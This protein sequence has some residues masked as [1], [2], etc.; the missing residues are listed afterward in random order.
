MLEKLVLELLKK[1]KRLEKRGFLDYRE[2]KVENNVIPR[3]EGSSRVKIGNTEVIAGIK[4]ELSE[5][6]KDEKESGVLIVNAE[7]API[8]HATFE[9]GPP[10]EEAIELAR[11]VDRLIRSSKTINFEKLKISDELVYGVFIDIHVINH[12]GNL[13]DASALA[14]LN[15][16]NNCKIPKYEDGKLIRNEI[17]GKLEIKYKPLY[18]T[19]AC[20]EDKF[21]V[22]LNQYEE[23]VVDS[24]I[25]IGLK[26]DNTICAIQL[27]S[28]KIDYDKIEKILE[29]A[30][31]KTKYLRN[32]V[33]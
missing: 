13:L 11:L 16:L 21:L 17:I 31:E 25:A 8:A 23:N 3:A 12:D 30:E 18:C 24:K 9:P 26:E 33:F 29:I 6:F 1:G 15:A 5:P 4:L 7:F 28:G 27:L 10:S 20:F 14:A 22:D 32:F 2:I 19:I